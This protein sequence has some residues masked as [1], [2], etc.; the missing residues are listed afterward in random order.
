MTELIST[1]M[2]LEIPYDHIAFAKENKL[3]W[4]PEVK[5]WTVSPDNVNYKKICRKYKSINL[6]V[7]YG[8]KEKVKAL[9]A[10]W[11]PVEKA[12]QTYNENIALYEFMKEE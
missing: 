3:Q 4:D 10:K 1:K 6:I 9:G 5:K 7:S 11:N 8:D 2:F 12:W